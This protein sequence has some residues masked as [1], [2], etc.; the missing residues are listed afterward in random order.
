MSWSSEGTSSIRT[1]SYIK[2]FLIYKSIFSPPI[3]FCLPTQSGITGNVPYFLL[4]L[5]CINVALLFILE[6]HSHL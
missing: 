1:Q 5:G 6:P 2:A 3:I 4:L